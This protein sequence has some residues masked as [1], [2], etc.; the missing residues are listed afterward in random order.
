M[1]AP[2]IAR[3][4]AERFALP[5]AADVIEALAAENG[6]CARP[7]HRGGTTTEQLQIARSTF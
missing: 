4:R 5:M 1:T 3:T 6:V 2:T 7:V